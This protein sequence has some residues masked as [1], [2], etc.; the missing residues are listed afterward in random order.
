[1]LSDKYKDDT[2]TKTMSLKKFEKIREKSLKKNGRTQ[3]GFS[4]KSQRSFP[5]SIPTSAERLK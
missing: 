1:M 5:L 4:F 3:L 2:K